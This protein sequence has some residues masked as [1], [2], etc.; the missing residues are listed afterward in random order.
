MI[1]RDKNNKTFNTFF[2]ICLIGFLI[3][4]VL[5]TL[6][7]SFI[8]QPSEKYDFTK[9]GQIGDTIG[10]IMSP[11]IGIAAA[12]LTFLAFWIQYRANEQQKSALLSQVQNANKERFILNFFEM[13]K[14][15]R[16]NVDQLNYEKHNGTEFKKYRDRMVFRAIF[17]EFIDCYKEVKKYSRFKTEEECFNPSYKV[18]LKQIVNRVNPNIDL[19]DLAFID[20]SYCIIFFGVG[21]E[22]ESVLRNRFSSKYNTAFIYRLLTYI[23]IKPKHFNEK[24]FN[25]WKDLS[26]KESKTVNSIIDSLYLYEK[27]KLKIT[28]LSLDI[29]NLI[30][31]ENYEKHYGGHQHRLG[32]Y[33]RHLFQ[34]YKYL[35][36]T[37]LLDE[38]EKY[39]YGK[40]LRAQLSTYEQA[41]LLIN[42]IS[43]LGMKWEYQADS[44]G[45]NKLI[46]RYNLI[47]NLPGE[48]FYDIKFKD[49]YPNVDYETLEDLS[50]IY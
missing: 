3:Y 7:P 36:G 2:W 47:K 40:T 44:L 18:K 1:A 14:L 48:S 27:G 42:S 10:G 41:L 5:V 8:V 37:N 12:G 9:T 43:T 16:D 15:Q 38:K 35:N 19:L 11:F 28:E 24:R 45:D 26:S 21:L 46:T 50:I 6:L 34:T 23:K 32:H 33:F 20:I 30:V 13:I 22:G 25:V 31:S 29:S 39:F 17:Q 49:Y 4:S